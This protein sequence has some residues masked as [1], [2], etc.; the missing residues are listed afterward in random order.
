MKGG[1]KISTA[2]GVMYCVG[3]LKSVN[4]NLIV[5]QVSIFQSMMEN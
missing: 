3:V 5:R 1:K 4:G 2:Y